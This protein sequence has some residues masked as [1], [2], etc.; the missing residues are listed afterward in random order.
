MPLYLYMVLLLL[1]GRVSLGFRL[2]VVHDD[3]LEN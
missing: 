1:V 2:V 3:Q